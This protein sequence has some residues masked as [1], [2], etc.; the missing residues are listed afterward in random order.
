L[1]IKL[2]SKSKK[3]RNAD[4]SKII[5]KLYTNVLV[6]M[7][8]AVVFVLFLRGFIQEQAFFGDWIVNFLEKT[9]HIDH[10]DAMRIYHYSIRNNSEIIICIA[11][12]FCFFFL[13]RIIILTFMKYFDETN[14]GIDSLIKGK[15][16]EIELSDE[17]AFMEDKLNKLKQTL[18]KREQDTKLAEQRKND[19]VMYLAHDIKTPL[20]SVI[21]YLSLLEEAPD[22]PMEQKAK[23]VHITL[24]K[25]YRLEQLIDEF[26]EITRY[27]FQSIIVT[28][29]KIDLYYMLVQMVDEFYPTL[30]ASGKQVIIHADE[31]LMISAD[32]DKLARVFN[33]VLKN[34]VAYSPDNSTIEITVIS[35]SEM[36]SIVFSNNGS[37]HKDKL[38]TIFDK[39]YRLDAARSSTIGG[40]GLG[41]AIAK[42]I[43]VLHGGE[44]H[45]DS[46]EQHTRFTVELPVMLKQI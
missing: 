3:D 18:E 40:A 36:V 37:I 21:G 11:V 19:L 42:E 8:V 4:Y 28:K 25:A 26:F 6:A 1:A 15:H 22:M 9:F 20:T 45:A 7:I 27:N 2:K 10:L 24:N 44:I 14:A 30:C 5:R 31:D 38:T 33:N 13:C 34:A 39:F 12:A 23:Y 46:D 35:S 43:V 17:M 32:P 41:L 29:K 16:T